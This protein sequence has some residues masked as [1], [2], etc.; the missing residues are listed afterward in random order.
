MEIRKCILTKNPC[1]KAGKK[2][3]PKG[4]VV[5]STGVVNKTLRRYLA[6]DDGI[7]GEN[8]Y[9]NHWNQISCRV[10]VHGFIGEDKRKKV[11]TY[12][13]LPWDMRCWGCGNGSKGSYNNGYI[14][15]EVCEGSVKDTAY[16]KEAIKQ[17][18]ELCAYLCKEYD[19]PVSNIVSHAEAHKK[20]YGSN[21]SDIDSYMK[22]FGDTM[23]GFR[24]D[25]Q[26]MLKK[27]QEDDDMVEPKKIIVEIDGKEQQIDGVFT[28]GLNYVSIRQLSKL[29]GYEV[30]SKG[31]MP[32]LTKKK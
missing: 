24:A 18:K 31:S 26:R 7:I 8:T 2:M 14:Q 10:C 17:A 21:H 28:A 19:I 32:I 25:V 3:K 12:Q 29:L 30:S 23:D 6:P 11:R 20:G 22:H 13:S 5:H 4:I 9:G 15:F 16:Y 1:Y 27:E